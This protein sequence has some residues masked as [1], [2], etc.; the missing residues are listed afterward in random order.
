M[1]AVDGIKN[2]YRKLLFFKYF[3]KPDRPLIICEGPTD[4]TYIQCAMKALLVNSKFSAQEKVRFFKKTENNMDILK[5]EPGT[6]GLCYLIKIYKREFERYKC[7]GK[8]YPVIILVD[9]DD[10]GRGVVKS[11]TKLRDDIRHAKKITKS[12]TIGY[13]FEN[14][15]VLNVNNIGNDFSKGFSVIEDLFKEDAFKI[16]KEIMGG[17]EL[18][19]SNDSFDVSKFYSKMDFSEKVIKENFKNIDFSDFK[20][21]I[22]SIDLIIQNHDTNDLD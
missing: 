11:A 8:E 20:P 4:N 3:Y 16:G 17:R 15:Y 19:K 10:A 5:L 14:L 22:D 9:D 7:Q 2:L 1:V 21:L 12:R 18:T 13:M 6:G